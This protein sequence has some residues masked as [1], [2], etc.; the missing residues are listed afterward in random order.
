MHSFVGS[1]FDEFEH[2]WGDQAQIAASR[3]PSVPRT[4]A[5]MSAPSSARVDVAALREVALPGRG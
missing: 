3:P 4:V 5:G 2:T 1:R